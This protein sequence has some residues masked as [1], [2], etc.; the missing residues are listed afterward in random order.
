MI[1]GTNTLV[2]GVFDDVDIRSEARFDE[3]EPSSRTSRSTA[4]TSS[5]TRCG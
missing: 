5:P 2:Y 3:L 1:D 4:A